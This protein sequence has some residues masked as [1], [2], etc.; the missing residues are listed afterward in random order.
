MILGA[1]SSTSL[2]HEFVATYQAMLEN[3]DERK[4]G[5]GDKDRN[6][7]QDLI[8][9]KLR[10]YKY[11]LETDDD[12][13]K[14]NESTITVTQ[15]ALSLQHVTEEAKRYREQH[16]AFKESIFNKLLS[17]SIEGNFGSSEMQEGFAGG[18]GG[19]PGHTRSSSF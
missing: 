16:Q 15:T 1:L 12:D 5:N 10:A 4:K 2:P 13:N 6:P 3:L 14:D 18:R 19:R 8:D 17:I 11:K 7:G 9:S